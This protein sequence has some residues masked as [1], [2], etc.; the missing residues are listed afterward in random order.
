[1]KK[2]PKKHHYIQQSYLKGFRYMSS[3]KTPQ[4][5]V[6]NKEKPNIE[7]FISAIKDIACQKDFHKIKR[8]HEYDRTTVEKLLSNIENEVIKDIR[9]V[10]ANQAI[11]DEDKLSLTITILFMKMR[12]P[13]IMNA[14][15]RHFENIIEDIAEINFQNN[16]MG[17][18]GSFKDNFKIEINNISLMFLAK[19]VMNEKAISIIYNMHFSLLKAAK[20]QYFLCSDSP[21][22]YFV[23]N[24]TGNRGAGLA[25][26]NLEIFLPLDKQYGLLCSNN[27]L[28]EYKD[29]TKE[30]TAEFNRRT[31]I[32]AEKYIFSP[33]KDSF[34]NK[35][36]KDNIKCFAGVLYNKCP[37][38]NGKLHCSSFIPVTNK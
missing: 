11:K 30:E 1:M 2:E 3:S 27:N 17:L 34:I 36:I 15:K 8:N 37:M 7:P 19:A 5:L 23:P 10:I 12:V 16:K 26:K 4:I 14:M 25:T 24:Y 35:L 6:Y 13:K 28:P 33:K 38:G 22:S 18:K 32:N 21:V 9:S 29:L 31:I 20:S